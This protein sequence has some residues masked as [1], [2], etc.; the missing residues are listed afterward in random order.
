MQ[1]TSVG[2]KNIPSVDLQCIAVSKQRLNTKSTMKYQF[3]LGSETIDKEESEKKEEINKRNCV[4]Q[5][6]TLK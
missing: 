3:N 2:V 6:I 5:L 1:T 4:M